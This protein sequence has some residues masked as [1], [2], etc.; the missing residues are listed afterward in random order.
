MFPFFR[1]FLATGLFAFLPAVLRAAPALEPKDVFVSGEGGYHTYRIP[2][3]IR[4][5]N[6][7]LLAFCEGRKSGGGD[8]GNIDLLLKRSSDGG[9]TWS[10]PQVVWDDT[11]NTCGNPC[12]VSLDATTAGCLYENGEKSR[13]EKITF[14]RVSL[15]AR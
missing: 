7:S 5:A 2:A 3:V 10:P 12:L 9:R 15:G 4:A 1:T 11:D 14:A 8:S 13:Y 6:G